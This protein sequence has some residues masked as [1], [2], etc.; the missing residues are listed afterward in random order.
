M[1]SDT[2]SGH[3]ID[4]PEHRLMLGKRWGKKAEE[5]VRE[6]GNQRYDTLLLALIEEVG[7]V[8]M[9]MEENSEII[10]DATP[11]DADDV[12]AA[13]GREI[14][15][16]MADLGRKTQNYLESEYGDPAGD[17]DGQKEY[18]IHGELTDTNPIFEEIEDVAPLI[19]QLYWALQEVDKDE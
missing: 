9:A 10:Y 18:R 7:E 15:S 19:W 12:P 13:V 4:Y 3:S 17:G 11:P 16:D 5:N 2:S 8:A 1:A 14:I 6:W